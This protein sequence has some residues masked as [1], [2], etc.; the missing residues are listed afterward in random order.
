MTLLEEGTR[1]I[2]VMDVKATKEDLFVRLNEL[3]E[4]GARFLTTTT[5]DRGDE[6]EIVYHFERGTDVLNLHVTNPK[7]EPM[8]SITGVYPMSFLAENEIQDHFDLD[9]SG[10]NIDFE[11]HLYRVEG[12]EENT[13]LKPSIGPVPF[14]KRFHGRCREACPAMVD[15]PEYIR[16]IIEGDPQGGYSTVIKSA[17]L[18][19]VLGRVCFAP[20][21]EGCRQER[22]D[23]PIQIRLLKRYIADASPSLKRDVKRMPSMGNK[24]AVVGGGPAGISCAFYLGMLGHD[25][26]V[27]EKE[28]RCGGAMLWGIPKYRL[29]KDLLEAEIQARFEEAGVELKTGIKV[30]T[31]DHLIEE[32]DAVFIGIGGGGSYRLRIDGEDAEGVWDFRDLLTAVNMEDKK[33]DIGDRV[34]IIGGGNSSIDAARTAKRLGASQVTLYYRR[35]ARE[36]PASTHEVQGAAQEGVNFEYLSSPVKMIPGDPLGL[37]LQNME[38]GE[39]DESG[40][41]RPIPIEGSEF[42]VEVDTVIEAIGQSTSVP[43]AFNLDVTRRGRIKINEEYETSRPE[44]WA[45]GD[46]VFGPSSVIEALRDGRDA[47]SSIDRSLGGEGWKE[48]ELGMDEFVGRPLDLEEIRFKETVDVRELSPE[49]RIKEFKEVELG[50]NKAE[51]LEEAF[52]CWRCHWNE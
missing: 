32:Y 49:E 4:D 46:I 14:I 18:P 42:T 34:A 35:T 23:E 11:G 29:P 19:A 33:P 44:V 39:P 1:E 38:L 51:A 15:A 6:L 45:G 21:E 50:F 30:E 47:A 7:G 13:L 26:T 8:P 25:V 9:I 37:V 27:F 16:Q 3:K 5:L 12:A 48:P 43:E 22:N 24:I 10:I 31:L 41:R 52:R 20:C 40:R 2:K 36:M 28:E 17:P